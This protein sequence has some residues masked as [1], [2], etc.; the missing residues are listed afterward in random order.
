[1]SLCASFLSYFVYLSLSFSPVY[2]C[3]LLIG[4]SPSS[5]RERI[6]DV[7][8]RIMLLNHPDK[9]GSPYLAAKINEAKEY[10]DKAVKSDR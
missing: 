5:P 4:I 3:H 7:H 6:R 9:G 10:L 2:I 8:K 1:M